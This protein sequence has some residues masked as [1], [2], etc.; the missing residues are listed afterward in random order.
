MWHAFWLR[1]S[2]RWDWLVGML[3]FGMI[4][5][6][7]ALVAFLLRKKEKDLSTLLTF[8]V[9]GGLIT[10]FS[11]GWLS[12]GLNVAPENISS[13]AFILGAF[14][15]AIFTAILK[16]IEDVDLGA[17]I[18]ELIRELF[19][20]IYAKFGI[21]PPPVTPIAPADSGENHES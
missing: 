15:G 18:K 21:R 10:Q 6:I 8:L 17:L 5:S 9:V 11:V 20:A 12:R 19:R 14:G 4:G 16:A 3:Q 13:F 7:G 1:L 2:E